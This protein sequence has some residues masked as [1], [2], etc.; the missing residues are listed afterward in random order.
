MKK[1]LI[2][3]LIA[4]Q[5]AALAGCGG[6]QGTADTTAAPESTA[7]ETTSY[8]ET[9]DVPD[10]GGKTFTVLARTNRITEVFSETETG[11][12]VNDAIFLRN[13]A[14]EDN[15]N[16]KLAHIDQPGDWANKD[17]FI[18]YVTSSIM[19]G[20]DAFQLIMGYMNYM[21]ALV[22]E[23]IYADI[24]TLPYVDL[25]K[26]WWT[27]GFNDNAQINNH[28]YMAMG[29]YCLLALQNSYCV[30]ANS[31]LLGDYGHSNEEL[32]NAVREGTWTF[33][34]VLEMAKNVSRDLDG[35]GDLDK[36][37]LHG[38]GMHDMPLRALTQAFGIDLTT[39]GDKGLP[40][41]AL[42]GDRL[43]SAYEKVQ[44]MCE[45]NYR[46]DQNDA[47][48]FRANKTLFYFQI[49]HS[50]ASTALREMESNYAVLPLPKYDKEQDFYRTETVDESSVM[51][52][53]VTITDPELVGMTLEA[54]NYESN[55]IVTPAYFET[56]L[57]SKYARDAES[58]EMMELI[59]QSKYYDF[60]CIF[61]GA[62]GGN[63]NSIMAY[64]AQGKGIASIWEEKHGIMETNLEKLL[65]FFAEK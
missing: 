42:Y 27:A 6:S 32:Y 46:Y 51:L 34:M 20:D 59:R 47:E 44:A 56:A 39:R 9:L 24:N 23:S 41:I 50:S 30:Y 33:D 7:P 16:I 48:K 13:Q 22:T 2:V 55:R 18:K 28:L 14:V 31:K 64:A 53:P 61:A 36:D 40:E 15:L 49:L 10:F 8:Y 11:D 63:I 43:V 4:A 5:L 35:D 21:P 54:L 38:I 52:V 17:A 45:S 12:V 3:L 60:G 26:T 65:T 58:M 37:D 29:D 57:Q 19:S 25:T 1:S 62:I